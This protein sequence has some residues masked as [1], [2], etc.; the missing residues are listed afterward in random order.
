MLC[1][2]IITS[3]LVSDLY[4]LDS[5]PER[6][7]LTLTLYVLLPGQQQKHRIMCFLPVMGE[8]KCLGKT[9]FS[10]GV[11]SACRCLQVSSYTYILESGAQSLSDCVPLTLL[12]QILT[13]MPTPTSH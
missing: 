6:Q 7:S 8:A 5:C 3:I 9:L 2:V 12:S 4:R 11:R 1:T 13:I 10:P